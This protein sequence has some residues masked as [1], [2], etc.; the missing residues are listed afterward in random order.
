MRKVKLLNSAMMPKEGIYTLKRISKKEFCNLLVQA[1]KDGI[2]E[3]YIGYQDNINLIAEWTGIT[4]P[5]SRANTTVEDRDILLIMKLAR[6]MGDPS[7]KGK[8][9]FGEG[10]FEFF[11]AEYKALRREEE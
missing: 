3:S 2:L 7:M 1:Q 5:F 8:F 9:S 10:D 6:R 11:R 4:V